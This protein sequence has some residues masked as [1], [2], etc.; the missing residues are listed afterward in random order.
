M[1]E[2][3]DVSMYYSGKRE[4]TAD[5]WCPSA[6]QAEERAGTK[7]ERGLDSAAQ[8]LWCGSKLRSALPLFAPANEE[9]RLLHDGSRAPIPL[10][11]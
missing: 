5:A 3:Q 9:L 6:V 1:A 10:A 11:T 7:R 2:I 4:A 8:S